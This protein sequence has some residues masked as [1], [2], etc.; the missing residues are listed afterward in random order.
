MTWEKPHELYTGRGIATNID[1]AANYKINCHEL[2][3]VKYSRVP[4]LRNH[5][6]HRDK[7]VIKD[8]ASQR[9]KIRELRLRR[10]PLLLE[11]NVNK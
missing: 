2:G 6:K 1:V 4:S 8:K 9:G 5:E 10:R 3:K 11:Y 7:N